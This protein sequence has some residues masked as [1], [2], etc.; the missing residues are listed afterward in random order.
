MEERRNEFWEDAAEVKGREWNSV[1]KVYPLH[2]AFKS[3]PT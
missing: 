1:C 3:N 2:T